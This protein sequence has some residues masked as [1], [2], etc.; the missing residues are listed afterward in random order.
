M[1]KMNEKKL[2]LLIK[3]N[4]EAL[5]F[6]FRQWLRTLSNFIAA[7]VLLTDTNPI[8]DAHATYIRWTF[9]FNSFFTLTSLVYRLK[10]LPMPPQS[11]HWCI[12]VC[13][14]PVGT[15]S[16]E[17]LAHSTTFGSSVVGHAA[18]Q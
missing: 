11:P 9:H 8:D 6:F 2:I 12:K 5:R 13:V 3:I 17:L 15:N 1:P 18:L 7:A 14:E 16:F 10:N 4:L